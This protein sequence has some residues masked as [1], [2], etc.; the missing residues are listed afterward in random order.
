MALPSECSSDQF[1][2]GVIGKWSAMT[3]LF[4]LHAMLSADAQ[5]DLATEYARGSAQKINSTMAAIQFRD[6]ARLLNSKWLCA[7]SFGE[8]EHRRAKR[9]LLQ[10]PYVIRLDDEQSALETSQYMPAFLLRV[11]RRCGREK[12]KLMRYDVIMRRHPRLSDW[13]VCWK[14]RLYKLYPDRCA[15]IPSEGGRCQRPFQ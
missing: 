9:C 10:R 14:L 1:D 13:R 5:F 2:H 7:I 8:E 4:V 6:H 15:K 3:D 11:H 12:Q